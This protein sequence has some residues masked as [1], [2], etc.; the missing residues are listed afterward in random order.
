MLGPY[1][2]YILSKKPKSIDAALVLFDEAT[3][4]LD[5][6]SPH[7]VDWPW[8]HEHLCWSER[9]SDLVSKLRRFMGALGTCYINIETV[10][11]GGSFVSKKDDPKDID[12]L[13]VYRAVDGFDAPLLRSLASTA[14][15]GGDCRLVPSDTGTIAL[16]KATI[17]YSI[18]FQGRKGGEGAI[19]VIT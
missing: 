2:T 15:N 14:P 4:A 8:V 19:M 10:L 3:K 13:I 1:E 9:R 6:S 16:L 7:V 5:S 17:F 12:A 18:L 11:L